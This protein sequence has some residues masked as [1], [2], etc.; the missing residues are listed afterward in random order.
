[1]VGKLRCSVRDSPRCSGSHGSSFVRNGAKMA[2]LPTGVICRNGKVAFARF[3]LSGACIQS[4]LDMLKV[5]PLSVGGETASTAPHR[6]LQHA[7]E[8]CVR[9]RRVRWASTVPGCWRCGRRKQTPG[10]WW[11]VPDEAL[12]AGRQASLSWGSCWSF[13]GVTL[14]R[15]NFSLFP[16]RLR[17]SLHLPLTAYTIR[18]RV[19]KSELGTPI[20]PLFWQTSPERLKTNEKRRQKRGQSRKRVRLKSARIELQR[21]KKRGTR[22]VAR[23]ATSWRRKGMNAGAQGCIWTVIA[24]FT[25]VIQCYK[26]KRYRG[27]NCPGNLVVIEATVLERGGRE[28]TRGGRQELWCY[29][30]T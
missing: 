24:D 13:T 20:T 9:S 21:V 30:K 23:A 10:T 6:D 3:R 26:E 18:V 19:C 22:D 12:I 29:V 15:W 4:R 7:V 17:R 27:G 11:L 2:L 25:N 16:R 8:M 1:M 14:K 5:G 28:Q